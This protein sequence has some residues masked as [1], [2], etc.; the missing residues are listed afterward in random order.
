MSSVFWKLLSFQL[1]LL[2]EPFFSDSLPVTLPSPV[3]HNSV[4]F[5]EIKIIRVIIESVEISNQHP[6]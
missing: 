2:H 5:E 4:S 6:C 1:N 3:H